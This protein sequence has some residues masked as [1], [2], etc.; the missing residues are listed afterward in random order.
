LRLNKHRCFAIA[1]RPLEGKTRLAQTELLNRPFVIARR[2]RPKAAL[3]S[4]KDL[5]RPQALERA[6]TSRRPRIRRS[7][8]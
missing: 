2:G 7:F 1:G 5:A 8:P 3:V 4:V 6:G